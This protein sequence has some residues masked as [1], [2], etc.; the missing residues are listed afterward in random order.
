MVVL[1]NLADPVAT[2]QL[3]ELE[4]AARTMGVQL[5]SRDVRTPEDFP[6]AFSA[7]ATE[8][9][10]G[11]LTTVS[12]MFNVHRAHIVDLA[13][14]HQ[15]PAVYHQRLFADAG[16][17]MAYGIDLLSLLHGAAKYVDKIL[18]GAKLADLPV[19]QPTK[20]VFVINLKT[21]QTLGIT[22]PPH[23]LVLADEVHQ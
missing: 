10:E 9:A 20:F 21:A 14:R 2:P 23:L 13:A 5:Q 19:E 1:T 12:G 3:Q 22:I 18:K 6:P 15:L 4:Q 16:G 17:L 8:G 7:A 11:L